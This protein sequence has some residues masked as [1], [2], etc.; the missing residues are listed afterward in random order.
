MGRGGFVRQQRRRRGGRPAVGGRVIATF[1]AAAAESLAAQALAPRCGSLAG[2]DRGS[3]RFEQRHVIGAPAP[4]LRRLRTNSPLP[5]VMGR[6]RSRLAGPFAGAPNRIC[7][8]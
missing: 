3:Q 8:L 2:V 6:D 7:V 5:I 4:R 1:A